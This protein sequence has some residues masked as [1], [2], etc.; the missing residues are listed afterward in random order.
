MASSRV[1]ITGVFEAMF[2]SV[3]V[4]SFFEV[5]FF[6]GFWMQDKS[7]KEEITMKTGSMNLVCRKGKVIL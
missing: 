6:R 4:E 1:S 5:L 7:R 3:S 2:V